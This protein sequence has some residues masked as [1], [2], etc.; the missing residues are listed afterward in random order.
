MYMDLFVNNNPIIE[1]VICQNFRRIVRS[2]YLGLIG[3]FWFADQ[4]STFD[5]N[6][7]AIGSDPIYTGLGTQFILQYLTA[8]D[9]PPGVG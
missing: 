5:A 4:L 3:D 6:G 7:I 8:S 9:L 2:L 1:G